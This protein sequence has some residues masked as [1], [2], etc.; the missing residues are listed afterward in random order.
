MREVMVLE[1]GK[2]EREMSIVVSRGENRAGQEGD[3]FAFP[4]APRLGGF[5]LNVLIIAGEALAIGGNHVATFHLRNGRLEPLPFL[6]E[7]LRHSELIVPGKLGPR[8][9]VD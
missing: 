7:N 2:S 1:P 5:D 8:D 3:G 9:G 4:E 6:R